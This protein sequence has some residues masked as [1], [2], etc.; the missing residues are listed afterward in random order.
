MQMPEPTTP[1]AS[2]LPFVDALRA[3]AASLIA[4]HHIG[5]YGPLA[6]IDTP[7]TD[8]LL[9]VA[10]DFRW[11]VQIFL[12][13]SG[14]V[15]AR[16]M[17]G[18][19][20]HATH[21]A[22]F[23]ARRYCRLGLPYLAALA[24]AIVACAWAR[25]WIPDDV[26]GSRPQWDQFLAHAFLLQDILGYESLAPG[27]WYVSI[28]FQLG[29]IFVALLGARDVL[30]KWLGARVAA[31]SVLVAGWALGAL[32]LFV[33][34]LD[35]SWDMWAIF[36]W[37]SFFCGAVIYLAQRGSASTPLFSLYAMMMVVALAY[38]WR[39]RLVIALLTGFS[40]YWSA[41]LG[42]IDRWPANRLID[43]LGRTSYSLFLIHFPVLVVISALW[44]R[45]G[46][47]S[48]ESALAASL[49]AYLASLLAAEGFY[50]AV[51]VPALR[52]SRRFG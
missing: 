45:L 2:R 7:D 3:L 1:E 10:E 35:E 50:R 22:R 51:E 11:A 4:W 49:F 6:Y 29:L 9:V 12:V 39:W 18:K 44:V 24:I 27:V 8:L 46:G 43:N 26:V 23:V 20:W 5:I 34:N 13:V 41:R 17:V 16:S 25:G 37:G 36:F 33:F 21:A 31:G 28:E 19:S 32:S 48:E 40:L 42:L 47:V 30:G 14:Y 52:L 15:T 38:S